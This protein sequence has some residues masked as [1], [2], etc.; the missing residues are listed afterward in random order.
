MFRYMNNIG[1]ERNVGMIINYE[2]SI[3]GKRN[4]KSASKTVVINKSCDLLSNE[5]LRKFMKAAQNIDRLKLEWSEKVR[6]LQ[7][8]E[9]N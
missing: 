4:L 7:K 3:R 8:E 1:E 6:S 9:F 5:P 2:L